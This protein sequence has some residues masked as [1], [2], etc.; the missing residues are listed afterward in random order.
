MVMTSILTS[1]KQMHGIAEAD[2]N[3]DGELT[4]FINGALMVMTQLGVG[5]SKGF[6]IRDKSATWF[7]FLG[8]RDDLDLVFTDV[9]LRVRLVFDPPQNAFLVASMEKQIKEYDWRIES[10]HNPS[11]N[12]INNA[13][14]A[15]I[16]IWLN[17]YA[18]YDDNGDEVL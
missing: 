1:I 17:N 5:S 4:M 18:Q 3:F 7:D 13:D 6:S 2:I 10:W 11:L 14:P 12:A 8:D 15:P 16:S 9:Y